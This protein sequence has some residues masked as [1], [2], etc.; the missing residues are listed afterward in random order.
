MLRL[1]CR[2][3]IR[4]LKLK[5]EADLRPLTMFGSIWLKL[6]VPKMLSSSSC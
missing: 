6:G 1:D 3:W 5:M 4:Q 2:Q